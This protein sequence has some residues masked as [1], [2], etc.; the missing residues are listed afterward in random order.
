[1]PEDRS[2]APEDRNGNTNTDTDVVIAGAGPTGLVLALD[3]ARRGVRALLLERADGLFPGS[4]GKGLQPRSQEVLDD[5]GVLPGV[6]AAGSAYPRMLAWEGTERRGEW[7][8]IER[9]EPTERVPYANTLLI[10]QSRTQELLYER[11]TALG[12]GVRFG[13]AL[14]GLR[15]DDGGV[16]AELGTGETVRAAFLV[17]ADGGRS[18]VRRALGIGMT[19]ETVDPRPMLVADVRIAP[20][21]VAD[22]DHWHVWRAPDGGVALCPLPGDGGLFQLAATFEDPA[23]PVDTTPEGVRALLAA[24]TPLSPDEIAEVPWASDYRARA[25]LADRFREGRVFLAGD[26][27]HVHSPAGGQGLNTG[28]QDAYN[29]GWKLAQVLRHG[30]PAALL[31]SYEAERRPVAADVLGLSTRLHR[32]TAD[33]DAPQRGGEVQQLGL[34]YRGSALAVDTRPRTPGDALRAGDRAPDGPYA[35]GRLFDLFRGP[36]FTLLAVG[37][38]GLPDALPE[39]V[40]AARLPADEAYGTGLFLIRPDG[41]VGWAGDRADA[42]LDAYLTALGLTRAAAPRAVPEGM[43]A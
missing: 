34:G 1:M 20:G 12:G 13:T 23:A 41:Y 28:V 30:A 10:P 24:R 37:T 31:D 16:E 36:H 4:R 42:G 15:Q 32:A 9:S 22:R 8:M 3:L 40:S 38:A 21:A 19:G 29:L 43:P 11:L 2:A 39:P 5:L 14:T 18:T 7:D 26:A 33:G 27:A 25:A 35:G 17:G 6:L